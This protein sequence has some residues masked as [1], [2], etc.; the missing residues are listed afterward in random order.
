MVAGCG[1]ASL[2]LRSRCLASPQGVSCGEGWQERVAWEHRA[3]MD[4]RIRLGDFGEVE[5]LGTS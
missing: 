1:V 3:A 4:S 5:G 2:I